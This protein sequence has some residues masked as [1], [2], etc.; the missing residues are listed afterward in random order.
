[1]TQRHSV[2][3]VGSSIALIIGVI[4]VAGGTYGFGP[5]RSGDQGGEFLKD[6]LDRA[7]ANKDGTMTHQEMEEFHK[8]RFAAADANGD[9]TLTQEEFLT[10]ESRDDVRKQTRQNRMT[11]MFKSMD[12]NGDG[13][14]N[15]AE[16][17]AMATDRFKQLDVNGDGKITQDEIQAKRRFAPR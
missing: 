9:G 14:L 4:I 12:Q 1:M 3:K 5:P 15:Q 8:Q 13:V 11:H 6:L 10:A 7:D 17:Q 2:W 16:A